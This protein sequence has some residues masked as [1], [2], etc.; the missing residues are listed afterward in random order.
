MAEQS[1]QIEE[2]LDELVSGGSLESEKEPEVE[3]EVTETEAETEETEDE[4]GDSTEVEEDEDDTEEEVEEEVS[5]EEPAEEEEDRTSAEEAEEE[6]PG[7]D[8]DEEHEAD[9]EVTELRSQL[10]E[11]T[12]LLNQAGIQLPGTQPPATP[13][14]ETPPAA[15]HQPMTLEELV[16]LEED[17]DFDDV[18]NDRETFVN[19]M[20]SI[21]GR[22]RQVLAQD[23]ARGIPGV[24]AQQVQ[25]VTTL[26]SAVDQFYVE[27]EDL[28]PIRK[29]VGAVANQVVAEHPDWQLPQIFEESAKRT[30]KLMKLNPKKKTKKVV[31]PSFAKKGKKSSRKPKPKV[32]KLQREIDDVID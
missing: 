13:A 28:L 26:R 24:V 29:T 11:M 4:T 14:A 32:S 30:R 10:N 20:R 12:A 3:E 7:T 27:N 2:M 25:Q 1:N 9:S 21:L 19:T 15:A 17:I 6:E 23:F 22:Y 31:T 18:M 8:E 5:E 16:I